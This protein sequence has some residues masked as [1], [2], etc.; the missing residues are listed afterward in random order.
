MYSNVKTKPKLDLS[1]V[2]FD[3][4]LR[5]LFGD[6][7]AMLSPKDLV[8]DLTAGAVVACVAVPLS[9]AIALASGVD[10]GKGLITAIIG[11][12]VGALFG[13]TPLAVSGPA[14]A[15][16]IVIAA[17]VERYGLGGLLVIALGCGLLQ[18][19]SGI[20]NLGRFIRY[21]PYPVVAGF[22]AGIG[23][24]ILIGQLPRALGLPPPDQS[25]VFDV[26]RHLT[27]LGHT[28]NIQVVALVLFTVVV[29]KGLNRIHSKIPAPL[30]AVVL[31]TLAVSFF[32]LSVP[33]IGAIPRSLPLP[34]LP[35][36]PQDNWGPL[37][38]TTF[39]VYALASIETLLS[40]SAVDKLTRNNRHD[41]DQ[42]LIGQGLA[43]MAVACFG[44]IPV[45]GVIARSALNVKAGAR[46][47][48]SGLFHAVLLLATVMWAAPLIEQIPIAA[49]A[50]VLIAV[51][52]SMVSPRELIQIWGISRVEAVVY[53]LTFFVIV[54]VDL[55]TGVQAGILAALAIAVIRLGK[56][57]T[58][59]YQHG[60]RP[61]HRI[62]LSGPISFLSS[63]LFERL[64]KR[65]T[66]EYASHSIVMDMSGV[67]YIDSSGAAM[68]LELAERVHGKGGRIVL[69]GL[70]PTLQRVLMQSES[71]IQI[72][73]LFATT[74]S[75]VASI[76]ENDEGES[77]LAR[78]MSGVENFKKVQYD[79]YDD[80]FKE[81]GD[82]QH[83]HTLFITCSD[84][85]INPN[86]ITSTDPGEL[87][88]LRN[89]GNLIPPF[90]N[91]VF[92]TEGAALE[93][94]VEVLE[95][96]N[97]V[98][99]GHHGCGAMKTLFTA[100]D[101]TRLPNLERWLA[102]ARTLR[103][104]YPNIET[105]DEASRCNVLSQ[106]KNIMSYP[107]VREKVMQ[108]EITVR[109]WVYD[110]QRAE[111]LEWNEDQK[112]FAPLSDGLQPADRVALGN[113]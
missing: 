17:S 70:R 29:I 7:R 32:S 82:N 73:T 12:A 68:V 101:T 8:P 61:L 95:V 4:G 46:T 69:K 102:E 76:I 45:T 43:N 86:L 28:A 90:G 58:L 103:T 38:G 42:E 112:A 53:S 63:Q 100:F 57:D 107:I 33:L 104:D 5:A 71:S 91:D 47:R 94:A 87:F 88:I 15:M 34:S 30:V 11:G 99:C 21:V 39:L 13:G 106:L 81:L 93:Y 37:L 26:I 67:N 44:G 96:R 31:S 80:I 36:L 110:M 59:F 98:V 54:L 25:H 77:S 97:I 16:A 2:R 84:S 24:I 18:L 78:L 60:S 65:F 72:E 3:L 92:P 105:A 83:P 108:G 48:R 19:L 22:T 111:L 75:A 20:L 1:K 49:L 64:G 14:A 52:I 23:A 10:P 85:R 79:R 50:G 56:T 6:W 55:I 66:E 113:R 27:Q 51:A 40:S 9:L 35:A 41:P 62:S 74:E 89:V 109:G